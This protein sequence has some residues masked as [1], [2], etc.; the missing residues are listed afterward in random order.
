MDRA[1]HALDNLHALELRV[2]DGPQRG[3]SAPLA[4]G[5]SW[6]I[7]AEPRGHS[8]DADIVL[9]EESAPPA[10]VRVT[11][12]VAQA[13]IEVLSGEVRLGDEVLGAGAQAL[14][15]RQTPLRIGSSV[16]AYGLSAA[17]GPRRADA[18]PRRGVVGCHRRRCAAG[19]PGHFLDGPRRR[20]AAWPAGRAG[21]A[22]GSLARE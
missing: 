7:A 2:L 9:H 6:V 11:A 13:L 10:R 8:V 1:A 17:A 18:S 19:L 4:A 21:H 20:R 14:W 5:T 12:E 15:P 22:G 3:A 16:V